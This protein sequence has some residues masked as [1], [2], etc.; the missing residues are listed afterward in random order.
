MNILED[1]SKHF[2]EERTD[3]NKYQ[4]APSSLATSEANIIG[5]EPIKQ[6]FS[7]QIFSVFSSP[8]SKK[9]NIN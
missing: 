2:H 9:S 3:Y 6:S 1:Q 5:E 4:L 8:F 7:K